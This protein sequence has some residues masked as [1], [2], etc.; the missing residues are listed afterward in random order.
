VTTPVAWRR[1]GRDHLVL[2]LHVQPGA[3]RTEVAGV[4]GDALK[5]RLAAPPAEG[6]ANAALVA[7]LAEAFGV[8]RAGV[9]LLRGATSRRKSVRIERPA[10]RPDIAWER[11]A[12]RDAPAE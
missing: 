8:P 12:A 7:F 1:E 4:H 10:K 6:R 5:V 9:A 3:S 2:N 11:D